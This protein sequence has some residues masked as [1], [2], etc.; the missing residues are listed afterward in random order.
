MNAATQRL[1]ACRSSGMRLQTH[2]CSPRAGSLRERVAR[3]NQAL[4]D[5]RCQPLLSYRHALSVVFLY[6][7]IMVIPV[8]CLTLITS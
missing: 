7:L 6:H 8:F 4:I 3:V 5:T 1:T 2:S